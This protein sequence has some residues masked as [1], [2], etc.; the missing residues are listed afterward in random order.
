MV[1]YPQAVV[2]LFLTEMWVAADTASAC[3]SGYTFLNTTRFLGL[4]G[5][6]GAIYKRV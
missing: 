1:V 2:I 4:G 5:K 6:V 3:L